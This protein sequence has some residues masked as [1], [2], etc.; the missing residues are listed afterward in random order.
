[1]LNSAGNTWV[2]GST[3]ASAIA[4][5]HITFTNSG[6]FVQ[7]NVDIDGSAGATFTPNAI[8]VLTNVAFGA[9]NAADLNDNIVVG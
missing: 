4:S 7:V 3:V 1:V 6:G 2:D 8:A 9:S 5:G